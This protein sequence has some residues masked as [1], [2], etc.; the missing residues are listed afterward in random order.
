MPADQVSCTTAG[1][2]VIDPLFER[3]AHAGVV[4]KS[5]IIVAAKVQ[6]LAPVYLQ[7]AALRA[8][9]NS[10]PAIAVLPLAFLKV[11][12]DVAKTGQINRVLQRMSSN[13]DSTRGYHW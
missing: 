5:Q 4:R 2:P 12:L 8:F 1:A 11:F 9:N 10:P 13:G 6:H 7:R 3:G